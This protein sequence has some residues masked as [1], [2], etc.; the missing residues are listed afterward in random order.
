MYFFKKKQKHVSRNLMDWELRVS[1]S[2]EIHSRHA[3]GPGW[4]RFAALPRPTPNKDKT[5]RD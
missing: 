4:A 5:K 3:Q 2:S 1:L